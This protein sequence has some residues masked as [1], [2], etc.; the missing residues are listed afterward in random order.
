MTTTRSAGTPAEVS[1]PAE[2]LLFAVDPGQGG[3]L[4][5][6]RR[7]FRRALAA[8][9]ET[10]H[11]LPGAAGRTRRDAIDE[12]A[13]AGLLRPE[14]LQL[15]DRPRATSRFRTVCGCF[16]QP[17]AAD[18]RDW[19]L[20]VLLAWSGVLGQRLSKDDRRV[21]DRRLRAL[22]KTA[23]NDS[24]GFPGGEHATPEWLP[25]LGG[26]ARLA[27][28]IDL[29]DSPGITEFGTDHSGFRVPPGGA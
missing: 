23:E 15:A 26:I 6:S 1:L 9:R 14:S 24:W 4:P 5:H 8:T 16:E 19:E 11:R 3:L 21:A 12:L 10:G 29:F 28:E 2:L 27:D 13:W 20:L 25:R 18:S 7:R 22:F 17:D